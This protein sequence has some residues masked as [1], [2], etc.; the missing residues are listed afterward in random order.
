MLLPD[1]LSDGFLEVPDNIGILCQTSMRFNPKQQQDETLTS[2]LLLC[3]TMSLSI[4]AF[5]VAAWSI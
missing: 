3:A 4:S 5:F 2:E 1:G